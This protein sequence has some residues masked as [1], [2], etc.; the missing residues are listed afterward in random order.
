M[1][2]VVPR[3][4]PKGP[5]PSATCLLLSA[6]RS[7]RYLAMPP[8]PQIDY[9]YILVLCVCVSFFVKGAH[10]EGRSGLVWGG[11]SLGSWILFT[12]FLIGGLTGGIVS[13]LVLF[14][15]LT[16]HRFLRERRAADEFPR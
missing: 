2:M 14:V 10:M 3:C 12:Q 5:Q 16:A 1:A 8:V 6:L 7:D 4:G 9:G 15:G 11:S 13:Q